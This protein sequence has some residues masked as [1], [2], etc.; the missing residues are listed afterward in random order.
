MCLLSLLI[1]AIEKGEKTRKINIFIFLLKIK[2]K[3]I[4]TLIINTKTKSGKHFEKK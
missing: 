2:R 1:H 3:K 4:N